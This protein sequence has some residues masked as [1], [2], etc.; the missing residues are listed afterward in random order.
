MSFPKTGDN[1]MLSPSPDPPLVSHLERFRGLIRPGIVGNFTHC[2]L[3][4]IFAN[5]EGVSEPQNVFTL[6][7]V[8]ER[9]IAAPSTLLNP[10]R[11]SLQGLRG[12]SFGICRTSMTLPEFELVLAH[13]D[14]TGVW[15]PAGSVL[16]TGVLHQIDPQ[17]VPPDW[18]D[19]IPLNKMLK[20]NF[21]AGSHVLEWADSEKGL[22]KPFFDRASFL[23]EL[24]ELL[25]P[26]VPVDLAAV[27][28]RLGNVLVQVP[29]TVLIASCEPARDNSG[30][31]LR[32][33]WRPGEVQ[34][35]LR[36]TMMAEY[37]GT[38][39]GFT[40]TLVE[41]ESLK[42]SFPGD[43]GEPKLFLLDEEHDVL[44][45]ATATLSWFSQIGFT[46]YP[47]GRDEPRTFNYLD[48]VGQMQSQRIALRGPKQEMLVGEPRRDPNGGFTQK[49]LYRYDTE[50]VLKERLFEQY[51]LPGCD[52][53][54]E[55]ARAIADLH[56]LIGVHGEEGAWLWDPYLDA[57]DIMATL[58]HSPH[59]GA[60]LR[61]LSS[62]ASCKSSIADYMVDQGRDLDNTTGNLRGLRLEYRIP[63]GVRSAKFHD[64][65]LIFPKK[66]GGHLAWSLG[67]SINSL[68]QAH[69][70]LQRVDD[71]QRV[72][73][74]FQDLWDRMGP[75]QL[76]WKKP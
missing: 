2:E 70:I 5:I 65:F 26:F 1:A 74:A 75:A 32:V 68:G 49:R 53:K 44:V 61:G 48:H 11:L 39:T 7:V 66:A 10:K 8:E 14:A 28:D 47:V 3:I 25:L 57:I 42:L 15:S 76:V 35:P 33:A 43:T 37:D 31:H 54:A 51:G 56:H 24:A 16:T 29:V 6:A 18:A 60:D 27:S 19:P 41:N 12:W 20:N 21:W 23:K 69:H 64:R 63:Y 13:F 59:G 4:E 17:F 30:Y 55:H 58:F 62:G 9:G 50:R 36:A 72:S 73:D 40:T 34:R 52:A 45:G 22:F 38:V 67:T 46:T 71:G